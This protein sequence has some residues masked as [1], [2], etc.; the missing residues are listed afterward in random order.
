VLGVP[1]WYAGNEREEFYDDKDYFRP[2]RRGSD[3]GRASSVE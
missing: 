2:A 1:G 3:G